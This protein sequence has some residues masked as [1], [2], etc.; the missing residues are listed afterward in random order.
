VRG[1]CPPHQ[2]LSIWLLPVVVVVDTLL[3]LVVELVV[4]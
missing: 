3:V 4:I 1:L 2:A